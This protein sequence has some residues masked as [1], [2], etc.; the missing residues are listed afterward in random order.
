M[1]QLMEVDLLSFTKID[2]LHSLVL[3]KVDEHTY[4]NAVP[5]II[6]IQ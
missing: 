3:N 6:S 2:I 5:F 1:Q 4:Y